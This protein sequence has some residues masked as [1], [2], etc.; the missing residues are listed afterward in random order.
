[1]Y[2]EEKWG[3]KYANQDQAILV[4]NAGETN[5]FNAFHNGSL[6]SQSYTRNG[7]NA[8]NAVY[9]D[10]FK[11]Y[12]FVRNAYNTAPVMQVSGSGSNHWINSDNTLG[13]MMTSWKNGL[14]GEVRG[15]GTFGVL[16]ACKATVW[17]GSEGDTGQDE[18]DFYDALIAMFTEFK[19]YTRPDHKV[20][21]VLPGRFT[22]AAFDN[23]QRQRNAILRVINDLDFVYFGAEAFDIPIVN[24]QFFTPAGQAT[25]NT[26]LA[27]RVSAIFGKRSEIG[28]L[29]PIIT[30]ASYS[31]TTVTAE[32]AL[33]GGSAI[34]GT[35]VN[36]FR[37]EEHR[38]PITISSVSAVGTTLTF[39]LASAITSGSAV[40][41]WCN[42][43]R[44]DGVTPADMVK[45]ANGL[46]MRTISALSV[47]EL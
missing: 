32:V 25:L 43:G 9:G 44:G 37:I 11:A 41:L 35:D 24:N 2:L 20:F 18:D 30:A 33:D 28:T 46:P 5:A 17:I 42:Y 12:E 15:S 27:N 22:N 10:H 40:K 23:H 39:T 21:A 8:Q 31:G 1:V 4:T 29:G 34:T 45:D 47:T 7:L 19:N 26:R 16:E 6:Y 38:T 14:F 13:P 3:I 36:Q